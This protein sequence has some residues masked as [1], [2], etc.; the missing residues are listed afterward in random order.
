MDEIQINEL[1]TMLAEPRDRVFLATCVCILSSR[2]IVLAEGYESVSPQLQD[3]FEIICG[4]WTIIQPH[5]DA[6]DNIYVTMLNNEVAIHH[7][8]GDTSIEHAE[9]AITIRD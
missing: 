3:V 6:D 7:Y 9:I 5:L 4:W 1:R 8:R 2:G